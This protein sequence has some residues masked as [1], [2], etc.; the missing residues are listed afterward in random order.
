[1][2]MTYLGRTIHQSV[3]S[4]SW[5]WH[6]S[7]RSN[8]EEPLWW[9]LHPSNRRFQGWSTMKLTT[10]FWNFHDLWLIFDM[11]FFPME[12]W[13][14]CL[15]I[16]FPPACSNPVGCSTCRIFHPFWGPAGFMISWRIVVGSFPTTS[17]RWWQLKYF[18]MFTPTWGRWTQFDVHIFQMGGSTTNQSKVEATKLQESFHDPY[19]Q[20]I[21]RKM[22]WLLRTVRSHGLF[23][24]NRRTGNPIWLGPIGCICCKILEIKECTH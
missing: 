5:K 2:E 17:T 18:L 4:K 20:L 16:C 6:V 11:S 12:I 22:P 10:C 7:I 3:A 8:T 23:D 9:R 1:M 13:K 19:L 14:S 15:V 21:L 24:S